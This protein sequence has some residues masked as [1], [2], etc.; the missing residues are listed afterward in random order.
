M[1]QKNKKT[2]RA[3]LA[4]RSN[5]T[6]K[7]YSHRRRD[8]KM[9]CSPAVKG[10]TPNNGSCFTNSVL[11][12]LKDSYNTIHPVDKITTVNPIEIWADLKQR[13]TKCKKEDCWLNVIKNENERQKLDKYLFAPDQ[14]D[15]W[16][17]NSSSWLSNFD[18][19]DV[20]HQYEEAFPNFKII[21]PTPIDF[22]TR[23]ADMNGQC[24][25]QDLCTF[26]LDKM[27]SSNKTKLGVVFNLDEHDE[28]GSH[29]VSMFID[30]DDQYIFYLD[31]AGNKIQP[32]IDA[33]VKKIMQ[34]GIDRGMRIHFYENCPVE[35]QMGANECGMYALY[36]I[37]TMLTG[38][39][40]GRRFKNYVDKIDF[41][42]DKRIPD[43]YVNK[44]RK[45]YFNFK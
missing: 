44:Y 27:L 43:R 8:Y 24:V 22:D 41:F 39:T 10:K 36:F 42:K 20:L 12:K 1:K 3:I 28:K 21:G 40:E 6:R 25:W 38:E 17:H 33:L 5:K 15:D 16:K 35:H 45:I 29:W 37:I 13:M 19:F 32:E 9:N 31:S 2:Q 18:I 30:L 11:T 4:N 34:Q 23:P 14:P 26:S 7:S